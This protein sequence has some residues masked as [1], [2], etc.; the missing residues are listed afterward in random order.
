MFEGREILRA[1]R[2]AEI[3]SLES[4]GCES[5]TVI[6]DTSSERRRNAHM[7]VSFL[8]ECW[9]LSFQGL[10]LTRRVVVRRRLVA[11]GRG[12]MITLVGR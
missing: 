6:D 3:L 12:L 8:C 2:S 1:Q 9:S 7:L 5:E 4:Q 11:S 10:L